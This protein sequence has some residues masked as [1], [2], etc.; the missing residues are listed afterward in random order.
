M[1]SVTHLFSGTDARPLYFKRQEICAEYL[2]QL[3]CAFERISFA[4]QGRG[5]DP[6]TLA[7][8]A[9]QRFVYRELTERVINVI[10]SKTPGAPLA[11]YVR[12]RSRCVCFV[13][14]AL[15]LLVTIAPRSKLQPCC[16]RVFVPEA[17]QHGLRVQFSTQGTLAFAKVS[18]GPCAPLCRRTNAMPC[19]H[20]ALMCRHTVSLTGSTLGWCFSSEIF[21]SVGVFCFFLLCD[22]GGIHDKSPFFVFVALSSRCCVLLCFHVVPFGWPQV[23]FDDFS[24]CSFHW[25]FFSKA[26]GPEAA[27][28]FQ[29]LFEHE[30]ILHTN[31]RTLL[32]LLC[33]RYPPRLMVLIDSSC[34]CAS[35]HPHSF[36]RRGTDSAQAPGLFNFVFSTLY[37]FLNP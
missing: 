3:L 11:R 12:C 7:R 25:S 4:N 14:R 37:V 19:V 34:T 5:H 21:P 29:V 23:C 26:R 22:V 8:R 32:P 31:R 27:S 13:I 35:I 15:P 24:T 33:R 30:S 9:S 6:S 2:G 16:Q 18:I 20:V 1:L 36:C 17:S 28:T 10:V